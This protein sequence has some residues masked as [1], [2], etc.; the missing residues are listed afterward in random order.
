MAH[1]HQS[2]NGSAAKN[3]RFCQF[4]VA[5]VCSCQIFLFNLMHARSCSNAFWVPQ[6]SCIS[7]NAHVLAKIRKRQGSNT[8]RNCILF[9]KFTLQHSKNATQV[10]ELLGVNGPS[11]RRDRGQ[12][13]QNSIASTWK[14][15]KRQVTVR[16]MYAM[17]LNS[18]HAWGNT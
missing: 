9:S 17:L 5:T 8:A 2:P 11:I 3:M 14:P 18:S 12:E 7:I 10:L 6:E 1:S 13:S 4:S 15:S 16:N